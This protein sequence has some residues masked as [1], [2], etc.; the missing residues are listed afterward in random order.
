[1]VFTNYSNTPQMKVNG[2]DIEDWKLCITERPQIPTPQ[3]K[4]TNYQ[5]DGAFNGDVYTP[6]GWNDIEIS[7]TFNFLEELTTSIKSWR[8]YF[9]QVRAQLM[10]ANTLVFNDAPDYTYTVKVVNIEDSLND[11]I[12]YG[13]FTVKFTC[14]PFANIADTPVTFNNGVQ[15]RQLTTLFSGYYTSYPTIV[16][17]GLNQNLDQKTVTINFKKKNDVTTPDYWKM[18]LRSVPTTPL[19]I[20]KLVVD[21]ERRL[22]Y[23]ETTGG[24]KVYPKPVTEVE[25]FQFPYIEYPLDSTGGYC[26]SAISNGL[27]VQLFK[28]GRV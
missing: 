4:V 1:M 25:M 23:F 28:N 26:R 17:S 7:I 27:K 11:I 13:A 3:P 10:T 18:I 21:G 22:V 6:T 9:S 20:D 19:N 24:T 12:E 5:I 2:V 15:T 16:V 8:E 14:A